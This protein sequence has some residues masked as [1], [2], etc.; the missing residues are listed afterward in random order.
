MTSNQI[1]PSLPEWWPGTLQLPWSSPSFLAAVVPSLLVIAM[2]A[3]GACSSDGDPA[4]VPATDG[5]E[6]V[7]TPAPT[8]SPSSGSTSAPTTDASPATT[9]DQGADGIG[10]E[11]LAFL[12]GL[13]DDPAAVTDDQLAAQF[14][15]TFLAQLPPDTL[16]AA[17]VQAT[18]GTT[19]PWTV[20]ASDLTDAGGTAALTSNDGTVLTLVFELDPADGHLITLAQL[21]PGSIGDL[22]QAFLDPGSLDGTDGI[23]AALDAVAPRVTYAV[24]D[25]TD[26]ACTTLLERN[27]DAVVPTGSTFKLWVLATLA[28][29]VRDGDASWDETMPVT[30]T[31]RSSPDGEVYALADGTPVTLE[32]LAELMISISDNTATDHLV[33]RLGRERIEA[34]MAELGLSTVDRNSP[35]LTTAEFF[36]LKFVH[37]ELG[38][39]YLTLTTADERREFLDA[40]VADA[41][42][43]WLDDPSWTPGASFDGARRIDE[44]EWFARPAD[45][46]TTFEDLDRLAGLPGLAP[47]AR[48]LELNP[49]L[50]FPPGQWQ[51]IRFKGGSEPGVVMFAHWM[52]TADG[53]RRVVVVSLTDPERAFDELDAVAPVARLLGIT[54]RELSD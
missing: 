18:A 6:S 35:F 32:R 23:D 52:E 16:R 50:P 14:A 40:D 38:A 47:V 43:P 54:A 48:I 10:D 44:I 29:A 9:A 46:C 25:A 42:L 41:T 11:R 28:R 2:V 51:T 8:S 19:P 27:G 17:V 36:K 4:P 22:E 45:L 12:V 5:T 1:D 21:L 30:R 34:T 39:R 3:L 33:A 7:S 15:P 26:G 31:L 24:F 20:T 53:D 13:L 49:G 37:P